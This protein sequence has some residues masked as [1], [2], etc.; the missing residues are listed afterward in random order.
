[1]DDKV[2]ELASKIY[3]DGIAKADSR[4]EE[5]VAA[6]E[7]KRDKILAEAEAKAKEILSRA[8]SEVSGMRERSLREL[9]L[10]ADRA[11]EA[12]RT[13]IGDMINDRAVSKGIDQAFAD[14]ER[15]YDVVLRLCQKLF[16]EGSN[17]VT[18]STED[19]EAL[20]K[21]FMN[22]AAG[23]LEKG[24][25]IKSVQGRAAS[26]AI[27]PA[28]KG[29]EVVVSKEALTEYFKDFMRPQLREALFTTPDK[30]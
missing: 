10:S 21:Y 18:V 29:Y 1:M 15:L 13:E 20:R 3:K 27:A 2:Q 16:D 11:S 23:I 6:A 17:S 8:E 4:A 9:Q 30:E 14:P 26:F 28:D 22:H 25:E 7:E 12:L 24:L 19:G 5:I